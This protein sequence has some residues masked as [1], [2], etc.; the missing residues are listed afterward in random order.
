MSDETDKQALSRRDFLRR[1]G[2]EAVDT[3]TQLVP[4]GNLVRKAVGMETKVSPPWWNVLA[5][6]RQRHTEQDQQ[7][8]TEHDQQETQDQQE[9]EEKDTG[10][11]SRESA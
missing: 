4:G 5:K 3:G 8:H 7:T 10:T 6:W 1:A 11:D 9:T 2:K